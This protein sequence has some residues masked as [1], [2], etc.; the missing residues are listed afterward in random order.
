MEIKA[1]VMSILKLVSRIV[2]WVSVWGYEQD[3]R[4]ITLLLGFTD[5]EY[6]R[7][8]ETRLGQLQLR[9]EPLSTIPGHTSGPGPNTDPGP[10]P[11]SQTFSNCLKI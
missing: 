4:Q 1:K 9:Y 8:S 5:R 3:H 6:T 7:M 2:V 10:S 11:K